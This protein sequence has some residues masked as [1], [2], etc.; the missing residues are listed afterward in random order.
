IEAVNAARATLRL[1]PGVSWT[2]SGADLEQQRTTRELLLVG[3]L[4]IALVFLVLAGEFAS[5]TTPLLVMLTVPMAGA[6]GLLFLWLTGQSLNAVS[7]IGIIVM[8]GMADNEAGGK[9]DAIPRFRG[10]GHSTQGALPAG[11]GKALR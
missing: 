7:L 1:P 9:L 2:V 5:F 6:G 8:I 10:G 4:S 11:G 3:V